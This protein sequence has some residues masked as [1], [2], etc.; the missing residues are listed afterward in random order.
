MGNTGS[1]WRRIIGQ[2]RFSMKTKEIGEI[3]KH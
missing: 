1:G 3:K 2:D